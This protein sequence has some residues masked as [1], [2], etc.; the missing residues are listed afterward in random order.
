M[1]E[2]KSFLVH[3][4]F[5]KQLNKQA[6]KPYLTFQY[7]A[8]VETFFKGVHRIPEGHFLN[9]GNIDDVLARVK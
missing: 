7:S 2:I 8:L 6:L 9:A 4:D 3:P 1:T 5:N